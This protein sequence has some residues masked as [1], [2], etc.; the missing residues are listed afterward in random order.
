MSGVIAVLLAAGN[1]SR[2]TGPTNKLI[3]PF[4]RT[5]VIQH[6]LM[7][8]RNSGI[9]VRGV[10]VGKVDLAPYLCGDEDVL[11]N[12]NPENGMASSLAIAL[13]W[14][15]SLRCDAIVIGLGDQP[16]I[17]SNA[18]QRVADA[19]F[20]PITVATYQGRR[21]NPVRLSRDVFELMPRNGDEGAR[22]LFNVYPSMVEEVECDGEPFDIDT[23]EDLDKWNY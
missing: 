17:G 23:A 8:M 10:V 22:A 14:G 12:P 18:W 2:F 7:A 15:S 6:S 9:P 21:R 19:P 20:S 4:R 3:A 16:S 13:D 1:S 11:V 5:T